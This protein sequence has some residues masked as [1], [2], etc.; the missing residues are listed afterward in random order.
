MTFLSNGF[1]FEDLHTLEGQERLDQAFI[2]YLKDADVNLAKRLKNA[3][4]SLPSSLD[5][6][7]LLL[8]LGS[9]V[10]DF[11]GKLFSIEKELSLI[12]D[13]TYKLAPLY[14]CKRLF[15]QRI[16][17]KAYKR[18][19]AL[20]FDGEKL[21]T[22]LANYLTK[23]FSDL[24]FAKEVLK[25]LE[26]IQKQ[27]FIELAKK[28]AAWSIYQ[29]KPTTLFRLPRKT[30]PERLIP[31][32]REKGSLGSP[33]RTYRH[34]FD[35]TDQGITQEDALDQAHYCILCHK[36]GKD[37]CSKGLSDTH[38]GCPLD[39]KI[40]EMNTLRAQGHLL[41][42][43]AIAMVDNPLVAATGH[44]ICNDCKKACIFQKQ[45][46]VDVPKIE[47]QILDSVLNLPWGIEIYSLLSRWNPLNLRQP[48][49]KKFS[50][51]KVLIAGM[52]PAGFT[53]AHYLLNEGHEVTGIDGL[54]ID[55]IEKE[56]LTKPIHSWTSFRE[57][58]SQRKPAG[59][60]GVAEYGITVRWDKNYLKLIRLLLERRSHFSLYDGV[61]LG[62]NL[63][64]PQAFDLGFDHVAL[65]LGAGQPH[66][67]DIPQG[68]AKGV[69]LASDFLMSLQLTG[70]AQEKSLA[71]L[72][73][74][75][76]ILVIGGGLTAV[77]TATEALAY[78][79]IQI[80]KFLKRQEALGGLPSDLSS[81]DLEIKEEF[82]NHAKALRRGKSK[83][84]DKASQIVYRKRIEESPAYRLNHE[85]LDFALRE[86][87]NFLEN[88]T[89]YEVKVDQYGHIESLVVK[90]PEGLQ[91]LPC[92]TL[93]IATGTQ[94]N[95]GIET[96]E[97][98]LKINGENFLISY[99]G[100]ENVSYFGDLNPKY[101]GNVVKAMASAKHGY[102]I[103]S[104]SLSKRP[105]LSLNIKHFQKQNSLCHAE[106]VS[107]SQKSQN[108]FGM[109]G[110]SY[111][112]E[113]LNELLRPK[114]LK[115]HQLTPNIWEIVVKA[116]WASQNFKPGQFFRLQAYGD[117]DIEG[118][119]LTGAQANPQ[120]GSLSLI[121]LEMGASSAL[122]R[123][124]KEGDSIV[125]MGPT[126]M[127]TEIPYKEKV[128]LM[129]G[130]LGNAVLFSIGKALKENGNQVLYVA[131]YKKAEDQFKR[132]DIEN[133]SD[134]VIWCCE[135]SPI[136]PANRLQDFTYEGN[137]IEG[138]LAYAKASPPLPLEEINRIITI[139]SDK[140]MAAVAQA[141]KTILAPYLN[142]DHK[143][144]G[145]I[146][147][148]MQCMMKG[149]CGQCIQSHKDSV[150][151]QTKFVF[152]CVN[153]D[154]YLDE[155]DFSVLEAR[156]KQNS[157]LEKQTRDWVRKVMND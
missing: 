51:Y 53:L 58:L 89:P 31:L 74:R 153:Q 46:P 146:N 33:Y 114:V 62:S 29:E 86:G 3:R 42:A 40:S 139:G 59:F 121:V 98:Y 57:S 10:E 94:P 101:A 127:P 30:D 65:C 50:G 36:Q 4:K 130:G 44:R 96:E 82:L 52:G 27:G 11:I 63:S 67:L 115:I 126:G 122:C 155:V 35:H 16:A 108:K 144:I 102:P 9:Y 20:Q 113:K 17:A 99:Q 103:I 120:E 133:V 26:D 2:S 142:P 49:P 66:M 1:T 75:L 137:V 149:I 48:L 140:M 107:A 97:P 37:S 45:D 38:K 21:K 116:P 56:Y 5:E 60:G 118:I 85:E 69:R 25:A 77:D 136:L 100:Q 145:S 110:G 54:K 79:P 19:E 84:M 32:K 106:L 111:S 15:V 141:R 43:L 143:A 12:Q 18:E 152:S 93:L 7:A 151:G 80:E 8:D 39:Q 14:R 22:Q 47:T 156:L 90:T 135:S 117:L 109:T 73:I 119:A 13:E 41:G 105:P 138:L 92:R 55:S 91:S 131:G 150:T 124:L 72:Q 128:L 154:Q 148:P 83:F 132:E 147:S 76:P 24:D 104:K 81:E 78:Y 28:Y 134:H 23:P 6:S 95:T 68:L 157:L 87:I 112:H 70:A 125:L 129:G 61:R 64:L 123:H 88:A 71:N 34:G